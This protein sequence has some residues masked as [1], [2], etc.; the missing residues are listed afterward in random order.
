MKTSQWQQ[1][2]FMKNT[3]IFKLWTLTGPESFCSLGSSHCVV[4]VS[5]ENN[6]P[7]A[8]Y[9]HLLVINVLTFLF[10]ITQELKCVGGGFTHDDL[11]KIF[12]HPCAPFLP[13]VTEIPNSC[14][15]WGLNLFFKML[16][17]WESLVSAMHFR[18]VVEL[19]SRTAY[20]QR[21]QVSG[22]VF[23]RWRSSQFC[24]FGQVTLPHCRLRPRPHGVFPRV[25]LHN[26]H[27]K[28]Y[29]S[30]SPAVINC[31][32]KKNSQKVGEFCS[33]V[34]NTSGLRQESSRT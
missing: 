18:I 31:H 29:Y 20:W 3:V 5:A 26:S 33:T 1:W 8:C 34:C 13:S 9:G 2:G 7:L 27:H 21:S 24:C 25:I 32:I 10:Y 16:S 14:I 12:C 4:L 6:M 30:Y 19:Y 11:Y 22:Q 15:Y 17:Q 28:L 23:I